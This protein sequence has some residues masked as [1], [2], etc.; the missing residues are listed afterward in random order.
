MA[1]G[2]GVAVPKGT[3]R[4]ILKARKKRCERRVIRE[5]RAAAINRARGFCERCGVHCL[6]SGEAHHLVYRSR[7]GKWTLENILFLC[8]SCHGLAHGVKR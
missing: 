7:G 3:P 2:F 4:R 1:V 8:R 6:Y 5:V